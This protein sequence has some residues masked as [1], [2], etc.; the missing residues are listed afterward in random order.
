M[1][2]RIP[3][4]HSQRDR[5]YLLRFGFCSAV[6]RRI[7]VAKILALVAAVIVV[8]LSLGIATLGFPGLSQ[9]EGQGKAT[10]KLFP[11]PHAIIPAAASVLVA[12]GI[13]IRR[14]VLSWLGTGILAGFSATAFFGIGAFYVPIAVLFVLLLTL[15]GKDLREC[16]NGT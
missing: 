10:F 16:S 9:T 4:E 15:I 12:I 2:V 14:I 8:L 1:F 6:S 5:E 3:R 7:K 13:L 11:A